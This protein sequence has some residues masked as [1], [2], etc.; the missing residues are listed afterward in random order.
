MISSR[1]GL[2]LMILRIWVED[3]ELGLSKDGR[4]EIV[5]Q[6]ARK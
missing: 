6:N 5:S 4:L 1:L 3:D 2:P